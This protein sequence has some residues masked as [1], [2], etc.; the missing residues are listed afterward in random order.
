MAEWAESVARMAS[1]F[2]T[3]EETM[4]HWEWVRT[5]YKASDADAE[6]Q[7]LKPAPLWEQRIGLKSHWDVVIRTY[8]GW[9][10]YMLLTGCFA[11]LMEHE[12]LDPPEVS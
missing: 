9:K 10:C 8:R 3:P 2:H 4:K 12:P 1:Y 5:H 6:I 11:S 7:N